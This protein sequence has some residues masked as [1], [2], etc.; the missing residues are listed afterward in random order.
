LDGSGADTAGLRFL[1]GGSVQ[2]TNL[3][4]LDHTITGF[5]AGD[6]IDLRGMQ[7][8]R[9]T[10]ANAPL[11]L[12]NLNHHLAP[13]IFSGSAAPVALQWP[14]MGKAERALLFRVE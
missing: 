1:G 4:K 3:A 11:T 8:T 7:I 12:S 2:A 14:A 10:Y 5:A 6:F 13:L 9:E